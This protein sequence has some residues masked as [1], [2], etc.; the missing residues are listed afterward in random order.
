[1]RQ[2]SPRGSSR[3]AGDRAAMGP[4]AKGRRADRMMDACPALPIQVENE[5]IGSRA[6]FP[7]GTP[8]S[9]ERANRFEGS[10]HGFSYKCCRRLHQCHIS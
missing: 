4:A 8:Q 2:A 9:G 10:I 7:T 6:G 1:M 5:E 3:E